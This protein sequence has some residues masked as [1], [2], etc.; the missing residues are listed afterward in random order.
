MI[1]KENAQQ[2]LFGKEIARLKEII[3][4]QQKE[5][6]ELKNYQKKI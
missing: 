5:I 3:E 2:E 4:D 1:K 6:E